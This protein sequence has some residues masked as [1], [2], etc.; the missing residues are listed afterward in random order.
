MITKTRVASEGCSWVRRSIG[1]PPIRR[2]RR[3]VRSTPSL[4]IAF[5]YPPEVTVLNPWR[6]VR[7][8]LSSGEPN[9]MCAPRRCAARRF[10]QQGEKPVKSSLKRRVFFFSPP[11]VGPRWVNA[12]LQLFRPSLPTAQA[13]RADRISLES[14]RDDRKNPAH[15]GFSLLALTMHSQRR[16]VRNAQIRKDRGQRANFEFQKTRFESADREMLTRLAIGYATFQR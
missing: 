3:E 14:R 4:P 8:A 2:V 1:H 12:H 13:V 9:V 15:A 10:K 16:G 11:N 7:L 6:I 5:A